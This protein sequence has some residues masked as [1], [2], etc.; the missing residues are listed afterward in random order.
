MSGENGEHTNTHKHEEN[1]AEYTGSA[2]LIAVVNI[3]DKENRI[4]R[5]EDRVDDGFGRPSHYA[6]P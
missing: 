6:R 2:M 4:K 5:N 3:C 1:I